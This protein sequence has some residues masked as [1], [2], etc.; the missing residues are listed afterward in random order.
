MSFASVEDGTLLDALGQK[1]PVKIKNGRL[2]GEIVTRK[3]AFKWQARDVLEKDRFYTLRL[4][5]D[6]SRLRVLLDGREIASVPA[7]GTIGE[8]WILCIG[9]VPEKS[10]SRGW[11]VL[12]KEKTAD[13]APPN[14]GFKFGGTLRALRIANYIVS[15]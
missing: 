14:P 7:G 15:E 8:G 4:C 1:L 5:Y 3:G 6:L 2:S 13:D 11:N 10:R 9:G 12:E